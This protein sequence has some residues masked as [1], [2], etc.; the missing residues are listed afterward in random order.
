M[1]D[2]RQDQWG[3]EI[4]PEVG[5]ARGRI[6]ATTADEVAKTLHARALIRTRVAT[7]GPGAVYDLSGM[8]RGNPIRTEDLPA[9][10]SHVSF[11][12]RFEGL[13]EPEGLRYMGADPERHAAVVLNRV[14]AASLA[15]FL[16]VARSGDVVVSLVPRG[17]GTHPSIRRPLGLV[18]ASLEEVDELRRLE[19]R[20][21][22]VPVPKIVVITPITASKHHLPL[23]EF[24]Q[25]VAAAK[26]RGCVVYV[27]DAH[28]SSRRGFFEEPA[29]FQVGAVDLAVCST[30]KHVAGPRAAV[31]VGRRDLVEAIRGTAF[32]YGL[33]AQAG[34]YVGVYNA[35]RDHDPAPVRRASQLARTL[36]PRLQAR[37][38]E[39]RVYQAG[40]GIAISGDAAL[41]IAGGASDSRPALV[42]VEA[43]ILVC[44]AMLR[45]HAVL[46][47]SAVAMPGS[48]AAIRLM[49]YPDGER[50]GLDRL[51]EALADGLARL[52]KA[53]HDPDLAARII[54][55]TGAP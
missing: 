44:M 20:L 7:G 18:G 2:R 10:R 47:I 46:T 48:A 8:N 11:F 25:A 55:G 6:L 50:L 16:T 49:L 15:V 12:E 14:S 31:L 33:D 13:A 54:L 26:A 5:Y 53:L 36:L 4:D 28:L 1:G 24:R 21:A 9:L 17:G 40:P 19:Q 34:Q 41:A 3:N 52:G 27:D 51:E 30:D 35:L 42:P 39:G 23:D 38:G 22:T 37:Y 43:N 45:D 29:S 32:E